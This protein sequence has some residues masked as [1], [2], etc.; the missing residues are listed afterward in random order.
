MKKYI[1]K[2]VA[3]GL[4]LGFYYS[5]DTDEKVV[6]QILAQVGTGGVIRTIDEDND[7]VFNDETDSFD[8][9][10]SYTI[11]LEEQDEEGGAL[12]ESV[13]IFVNFDDNSDNGADMSTTEVL[14]QTLAASDFSPGD[15]SLPQATVSYTSDELIA[16]TGID[17]SL[18]IGK[19]RFEFRLVLTLT[20]GETYT[21]SDVGGPVSGGSYFASPF[22]Y[23]PVIA[24]SITESL[25]G[26]H[27]YVVTNIIPAP[28]GG[29][30]CILDVLTGTVTWSETDDAGVYTSSDMSFG[31]FENCY[32]GRGAAT[33]EDI[34]IEWD[35]TNL[36]PDGEVYLKDGI[37]IPDDDD[38]D[39][40]ITYNYTITNVTGAAMTINFANSSGDRGTVVLTRE[41]GA[42][43]PVIFTANNE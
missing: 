13:E 18:V 42:N 21:N 30:D 7:L 25:A 9:G 34:E 1:S 40:E 36:V 19:D 23:F 39:A 35:C 20:N 3:L 33:G 8:P 27:A 4:I 11:V 17:E 31:Q 14:L 15:R 16:A 37:V 24:C 2:I 41:G 29:G 10:S 26:E 22:E 5:C 38:E 6:D 12:L 28:G 32:D 43:W